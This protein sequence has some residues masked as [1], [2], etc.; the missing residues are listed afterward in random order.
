MF[1]DKYRSH[2]E[3]YIKRSDKRSVNTKYRLDEI[4]IIKEGRIFDDRIRSFLLLLKRS[5]EVCTE[6]LK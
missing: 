4:S 1:L 3:C 2:L 6:L 5:I